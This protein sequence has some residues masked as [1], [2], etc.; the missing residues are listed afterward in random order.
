MCVYNVLL[1]HNSYACKWQA[2]LSDYSTKEIKNFNI[3][4]TSLKILL[5]QADKGIDVQ[6]SLEQSDILSIGVFQRDKVDI[7][8][9]YPDGQ[10]LT[11]RAI[12]IIDTFTGEKITYPV[13]LFFSNTQKYNET[14][15]RLHIDC[16]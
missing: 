7:L 5:S 10:M 13:M 11:T 6:C 15:Y 4:A 2:E 8:C 12:S 1:T 3:E 16:K 14:L 9:S